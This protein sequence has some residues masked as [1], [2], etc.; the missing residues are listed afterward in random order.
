MLPPGKAEHAMKLIASLIAAGLLLGATLA[1]ADDASFYDKAAKGGMAEVMAGKLAARK[2]TNGEV[3][4]FGAM[5]VKDHGAANQKL[6]DIAKSKSIKL[7][8]TAG[9]EHLAQYK[10]LQSQQG[11]RFDAAYLDA[12]VKAHEET[13]Q[14]LKA[15]IASGQ[16]TEAKAFAQEI[17]PTVEA[18]L[19]EAKRLTGEP[20]AAAGDAK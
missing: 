12:Q 8:E 7:P 13:V 9:E 19:R 3:R 15:E 16:D 18:H 10:S 14:L 5:M 4:D 6:A 2:A 20:E 1:Q 11:A 17:L